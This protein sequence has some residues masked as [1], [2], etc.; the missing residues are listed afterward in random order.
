MCML[1][2]G[3]THSNFEAVH[4]FHRRQKHAR[5]KNN[6][7]FFFASVCS[8]G[9]TIPVPGIFFLDVLNLPKCRVP[10]L[11]SYRTYRIVGYRY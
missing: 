7:G 3:H 5:V 9:H 10:V 6:R 2:T 11:R 8:V 1:D 4:V